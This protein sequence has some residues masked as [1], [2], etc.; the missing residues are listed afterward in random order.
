M[1]STPEGGGQQKS[2]KGKMNELGSS[3][4]QA[5]TPKVVKQIN[6]KSIF[7][8]TSS[9]DTKTRITL[10]PFISAKGKCDFPPAAIVKG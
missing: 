10:L 1:G 6:K 2:A 8:K 4:D 7:K 3:E 5:Y 9:V